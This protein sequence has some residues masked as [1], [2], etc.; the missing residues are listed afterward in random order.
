MNER[1]SF[2]KRAR[3]AVQTAIRRAFRAVRPGPIAWQGAARAVLIVTGFIYL[4]FAL[5]G[6]APFVVKAIT[7]LALLA[8]G[9][10]TLWGAQL[11]ALIVGWLSKIPFNYRWVLIGGSLLIFEA[12]ISINTPGLLISLGLSVGASS[13]LG[14][15][16]WS[17]NRSGW[18][19]LT[20]PQR[21]V[22]SLGVAT[23]A[24]GLIFGGVW[25][26]TRGVDA[27]DLPNAALTGQPAARVTLEDP[28]Q[29]G[30]YAVASLTYGSGSDRYRPEYGAQIDLKTQPVDG[31]NLLEGTFTGWV[32][33]V[34][35]LLWGFDN[36]K[37]LPL[38]GRVWYPQAGTGE[39]GPYPLV[40][41]VHGNHAMTDFSDPGYAYLGELLASRGFIFVSVDENFLN[42][43]FI[44]IFQATRE[45]NDARG[46][47]LLEHVRQ[48]QDWNS[49]PA[50]PFYQKVDLQ[51]IALIGHSRGG[52]AAAL[53]ATF[54]RL[55]YYPDNAEQ[56]FNYNFNIRSVI[57]IAPID[58]QYFP[59]SQPNPL[60]NVNYFVLHG[61][62]DSDVT[63][64]DGIAQYERLRFTGT[65]DWFKSALYIYRAN[66]GQFNTTWGDSDL[67][68]LMGNFLNRQA[69]LSAEQQQQIAKVYLSAFL[70]ATL[71]AQ[72]G[73]RPL[74]E[75]AR[76]AGAGWLPDTIYINRYD[77]ANQ[78]MLAD[79]EEDLNLTTTSLPGG[80]IA[81]NGLDLWYEK[82]LQTRWGPTDTSVAYLGWNPNQNAQYTLRLPANG[83][84]LGPDASLVF[85]MADAQR[86][87]WPKEQPG[88]DEAQPTPQPQAQKAKEPPMRQP[89]DLTIVLEDAAGQQARLPVSARMPVQPQLE[90]QIW[91]SPLLAKQDLSEAVM[92][93]YR[94][95][96]ADFAAVNPALDLGHLRAVRFVFDRSPRGSIILDAVGFRLEPA[97]AAG[98]VP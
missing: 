19:R 18:G 89:T 93:S 85:A 77:S 97:L 74:F 23:G 63:S 30:P 92:Q 49:D 47:L 38:N 24:A 76:A 27:R 4:L 5:S 37:A 33:Q 72:A 88:E 87:P 50:S 90:A 55:P 53:A 94:F 41:M 82:R 11:I 31:S 61:S 60:E 21:V 78:Q 71:H 79:Y 80:Q 40:V 81:A 9:A 3:L 1:P 58:G 70:E 59:G 16:L 25:L 26:L 84:S 65:G 15:G 13:L 46:W 56:V 64:F 73:Y 48:W 10:L 7:I 35:N 34:R 83:L 86:D 29:P 52:E 6:Q 57:A 54:N 39:T 17:L 51:N 91:K 45:E 8:L 42:S 69:L 22:A 44:N 12:L 32:G 67:S 68:Y 95:P 28:S 43:D 98:G 62:H 75:D 14:A 2:V 36:V 96:L 66:H 20:V